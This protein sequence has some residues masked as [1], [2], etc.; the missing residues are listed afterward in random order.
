MD[1]GGRGVREKIGIV[2]LQGNH[3]QKSLSE[4]KALLNKRKAKKWII[5]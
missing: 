5:L 2:E 3:K 1:L 4:E